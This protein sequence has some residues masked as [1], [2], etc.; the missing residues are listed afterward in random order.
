MLGLR[1]MEPIEF[2]KYIVYSLNF[3]IFEFTWFL[4]KKFKKRAERLQKQV[5]AKHFLRC[6]L[7]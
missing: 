1:E 3:P 5:L 6:N 2:K 4:K 7:E